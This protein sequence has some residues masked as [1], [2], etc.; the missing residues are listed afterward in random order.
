MLL[1]LHHAQAQTNQTARKWKFYSINQAGLLNGKSG[2]AFH[3]QSVNGFQHKLMFAGIGAGLDY[4]RYRSIPVFAELRNY[5]GKGPNRFFIYADGGAHFVWEKSD[6]Q[7]IF[8]SH[9][10]PGFYC[11]M[12]VGY[13]AVFKNGEGLS[14][15]AGYSYK[16]VKY[17]QDGYL[18]CPFD[19]PCSLRKET[20]N[21][22]LNRLILQ[23]GWMF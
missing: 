8:K 14:L 13:Q 7:D 6:D 22:D 3:A 19:G 11:N 18:F 21:Y 20:Y 4:Y 17:S 10:S 15:S 16:K 2:T 12:G 9:Y 23:I 5:F 1:L